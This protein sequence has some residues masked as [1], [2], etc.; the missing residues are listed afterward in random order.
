MLPFAVGCSQNSKI[1]R[2]QGPEYGPVPAQAMNGDGDEGDCDFEEGDECDETGRPCRRE[3]RCRAHGARGCHR[4]FGG[5]GCQG[6]NGGCDECGCL[7]G[8]G[9][10]PYCVPNDLVYPPPG[11]MPGIVQYPYYTNKGP[12]CFFH[13]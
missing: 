7:F 6:C 4:C 9:G 2:G 12:D 5:N 8:H 13:R 10:R 3:R 11:D 1:V